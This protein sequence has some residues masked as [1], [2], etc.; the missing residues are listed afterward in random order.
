M[1]QAYA[2]QASEA[3]HELE[4]LPSF[5]RIKNGMY[6]PMRL[7]H[8]ESHHANGMHIGAQVALR[9]AMERAGREDELTLAAMLLRLDVPGNTPATTSLRL[10]QGQSVI[11]VQ[12][13][14][15]GLSNETGELSSW[16]GFVREPQDFSVFFGKF[17]A[18]VEWVS[19]IV[20][21]EKPE[22]YIA[23]QPKKSQGTAA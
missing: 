12:A 8:H 14:G 6:V 16:Q 1:A 20:Q 10:S 5:T 22:E 15:F 17:I 18:S 4:Q 3:A 11:E 2:G 21:S 7:W 9:A 23:N 13:D 19:G